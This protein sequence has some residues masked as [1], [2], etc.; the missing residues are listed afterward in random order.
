MARWDDDHTAFERPR[1]RSRPRTK[2]RPDYSSAPVAMV[3]SIDR[4]RYRC[5]MT[6]GRAVSAT[7]ARI[8]GRK[9]VIVGDRVRLD[10]DVSGAEGTLARIVEVEE[11]SSMLRRSADDADT[12]ERPIVA[13]ADQL[14]IVTALADP[15]PRMGMIDRILV[16]AY[17]AGVAPV[18]C[19]TK[20]DLASPDALRA[21]YEP[22][23]VP[24]VVTR[25]GADLEPVREHLEDL[26]TVL[27]GHSGVGKSTLVN[28]LVPGTGRATGAVSEVTGKGRHTSTSAA[29]IALPGGGWIIDTPGVRS[30]GIS[31]VQPESFVAAFS[32]LADL[33]ENCPRGCRHDSQALECAL[34]E[35]LGE[36]LLDAQRLASFRRMERAF[37]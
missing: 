14:M 32:D 34:D 11:R 12:F 17:D 27:I 29:A 18:L 9:G 13:N 19:L 16:A 6:D 35:A 21:A 25:P 22:L 4:G 2:D 3:A 28:A 10:G 26:T 15:E 30:F 8:L 31:H 36:G 20:A 37:A 23:G 5:L 24:I 1:R 7:K 33:V